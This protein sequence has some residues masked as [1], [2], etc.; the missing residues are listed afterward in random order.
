MSSLGDDLWI[1]VTDLRREFHRVI[2]EVEKG[3]VF[4][5]MRRGRAVARLVPFTT[6]EPT[7]PLVQQRD[8]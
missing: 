4:T 8:S 6:A 1:T 2:R 5:I 7:V 3:S